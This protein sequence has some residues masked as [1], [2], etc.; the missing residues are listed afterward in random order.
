VVTFPLALYFPPHCCFLLFLCCLCWFLFSC[1]FL[2]GLFL[3]V[4]GIPVPKSIDCQSQ[5]KISSCLSVFLNPG[6]KFSENSRNWKIKFF[7]I[8]HI[9][10]LLFPMK[11][12]GDPPR[13]SSGVILGS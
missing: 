2:T 9:D 4:V 10:V 8:F 6:K 3:D 11:M 1:W 7:T 5:N 12:L 13:N